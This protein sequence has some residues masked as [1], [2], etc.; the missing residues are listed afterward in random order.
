MRLL[1]AIAFSFLITGCASNARRIDA[2]AAA[3]GLER[4]L[5]DAA[6]HASLIYLRR[7]APPFV[8]FLEGD[9]APW[10]GGREPSDDPTTR[11][12]IALELLLRSPVAGAYVT[13]PC[14]HRL[15]DDRCSPEHWTSARYSE[16]IVASMASAVREA[17]QSA[18]AARVTLI[19]YSGGGVLAVLV[20]E[21]LENVS[22]VVT[23]AANLDTDA[24]TERHDYLPLSQS[25]NPARSER[26]HPW[27]E[28]H[29]Q[30]EN[31]DRVPPESTDAYFK[32]YPSAT[33]E[34]LAGYDHVC[35]WLDAWPKIWRQLGE[36]ERN[37]LATKTAKK[38]EGVRTGVLP[39][40]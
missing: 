37:G 38:S 9:G 11:Q 10:K 15:G 36:E 5:V 17:M 30:G 2:R 8:V 39:S 16:E 18:S 21:R 34:T 40:R 29:F 1:L 4:T 32:R 7:G 35:C 27:A 13:R 25:L 3:A 14:Y 28:L 20:A 31:D 19:G 23:I 24:W 22:A 26:A 6:G 33:R 12:P